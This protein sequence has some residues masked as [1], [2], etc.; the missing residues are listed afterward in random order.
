MCGILGWLSPQPVPQRREPFG[1]ALDLL[2][3]RGPDDAGIYAA[4]NILMGHRR[5][6]ILDLSPRGHQP[7]VDEETG[8]VVV[9]NGEIYNFREIRSNLE[10]KGVVFRGHSD[11]EVLLRALI[12]WRTAVLSKFNGMWGF[13]FW[14]PRD[15]T[16]LLSRDRFGVKPLY[17]ISNGGDLAFASEPKALLEIFQECREVDEEVLLDFLGNNL[18][19]ARG[20][21]FYKGID[22]L[23]PAHYGIW[24]ESGKCIRVE[25]YW[26]YPST[27]ESNVI[28]PHEAAREFSEIF[29][30]SVALRLRS[31]VEVGI[32]L[33]GG[34]DSSGVLAA[35]AHRL[36]E[37]S[38]DL[39]GFTSTYGTNAIGELPWAKKASAAAG[40]KL[41]PVEAPREGWLETM[42]SIVWH[43]DAPGYSPAVYPLWYLVKEARALGVIVLL[44]GQGADEALAG[45][46]QYAVLDW[47]SALKQHRFLYAARKARSL[48]RTFTTKWTIAWMLREMAP[49]L[50]E[51][52]RQKRGFASLMY[53]PSGI[54]SPPQQERKGSGDMVWQ[55][56]LLD[57][58]R[59]ILP[60]LLHY[61]DA[62]SMAHGVESRNPFL[63]FR[64][65]EWLFRLPSHLRFHR[66]ETKWVLREYLRSHGMKEIG[67]RPDKQ[68]YPTPIGNWLASGEGR[69]VEHM[70]V[71]DSFLHAWCDPARI[72]RLFDRHRKGGMTESH[73][74]Y[75][76]LSA[77]TWHRRCIRGWDA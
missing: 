75:K 30:D 8:C 29:E 49:T 7:M 35:M 59:N 61:G 21:S 45:Y 71:H 51:L 43:M 54:P 70:L 42:N 26:D 68:G 38:K 73:L 37:G 50:F 2:A 20:R 16:L 55:R 28:E 4:S 74:L 24:S 11:S 65:V 60:G 76:L 48:V 52:H 57:H 13:A 3:H 17:Y 63:D 10:K 44:E 41:I 36:G 47:L 53:D 67:D 27:D 77:E 46:P 31:D 15:R 32:T 12:E 66:G 18:L 40:T 6:S 1:R 5:L 22:L 14:D 9:F 64:L 33:S 25:K 39:Y 69:E 58:A 72:Q 62:I 56:L 23:P 34:L 19:Y